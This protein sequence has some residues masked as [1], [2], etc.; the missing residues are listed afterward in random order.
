MR[1]SRSLIG[2]QHHISCPARLRENPAFLE[3]CGIRHFEAHARQHTRRFYLF[4]SELLRFLFNLCRFQTSKDSGKWFHQRLSESSPD[5]RVNRFQSWLFIWIHLAD[6]IALWFSGRSQRWQMEETQTLLFHPRMTKI[7]RWVPVL[8]LSLVFPWFT[9]DCRSVN[10]RLAHRI[11]L[12]LVITCT[13][14]S[15]VWWSPCTPCTS[16]DLQVLL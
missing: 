3:N 2:Q 13:D 14:L 10:Q 15:I 11:V 8:L 6:S 9:T 16:G 1:Q 7:A 5:N 4:R 12:Y